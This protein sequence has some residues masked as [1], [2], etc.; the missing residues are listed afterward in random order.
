MRIKWRIEGFREIRLSDG[1]E[2]H[3][4]GLAEEV[5]SAAGTGFQSLPT[6]NP[7]NRARAAVVPVTASAAIRNAREQTLLK[8]LGSRMR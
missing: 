4:H 5:A 1:V 6:A 2:R 7:R 8:A 3:V